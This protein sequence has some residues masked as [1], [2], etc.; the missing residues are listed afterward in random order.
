M[1]TK[2]QVGLKRRHVA[3]IQ[4]A[5]IVAAVFDV[6]AERGAANIAVAQIVARAGVSRR[7]FYELFEDCESCVLLALDEAIAKARA[8][9]VAAYDPSAPWAVRIRAALTALLQFLDEEPAVGRMLIVESLAAGHTALVRRSQA[10]EEIVAVLEDGGDEPGDGEAPPP[11]TAEGVVGAVLFVLHSRMVEVEATTMLELTSPL[12]SVI[13]LP[14]HGAAAASI[15]LNQPI[16]APTAS[17]DRPNDPVRALGVRLTY[18]TMR[19]L[20]AIGEQPGASN[21]QVG[22]GAG[23]EDP[24]QISKLLARLCRHGL[25]VNKAPSVKGEANAWELTRKGAEI[26]SMIAAQ[27]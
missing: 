9:A 2:A 21:R 1:T 5:R 20:I 22:R 7:T 13:V 26:Q 27:I 12:M 11:L 19:V 8:R 14:Y 15:E 4:R 23:V 3:D 6:C 24:G 16:A 18:R 17:R 25:I 10:I